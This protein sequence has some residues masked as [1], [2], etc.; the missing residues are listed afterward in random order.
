[1]NARVTHVIRWASRRAQSISSRL[2]SDIGVVNMH[3]EAILKAILWV[4]PG[5]SHWE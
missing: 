5:H 4:H 3:G 2:G 1:M